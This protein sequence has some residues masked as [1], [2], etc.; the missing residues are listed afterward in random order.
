[1]KE[2]SIYSEFVTL[3]GF[4]DEILEMSKD[5]PNIA[6]KIATNKIAI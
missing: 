1:M 4:N 5:L 3:F 6:N 2:C